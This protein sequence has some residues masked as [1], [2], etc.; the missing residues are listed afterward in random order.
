[1]RELK[2][3]LRRELIARRKAMNTDE[4][5]AADQDIF[6]QVKPYLDK[7]SAVFTYASTDIEVDTRHIIAYCIEHEIP[8][9]LPVSGDSELDFFYIKSENELK[10]GRFNIDEPQR[11]YPAA[12][13]ENTLCIVPALCAD[14]EGLRLGYGRGYYDRFLSGF[15]GTSVILCYKSFR[16]EVPTEPHDIRLNHTIFNR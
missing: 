11:N 5:L 14:G 1:M 4:K 6:G 16:R 13:D 9:A 10:K 2:Q 7:A 12:A 8:V 15:I 3:A